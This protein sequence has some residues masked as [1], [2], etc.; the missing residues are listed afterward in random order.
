MCD[1]ELNWRNYG[2]CE[3]V[4]G[5]LRSRIREA[6]GRDATPSAASMDSQPVKTTEKGGPEVTTLANG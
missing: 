1:H 4:E 5:A 6:A 3:R 2:A